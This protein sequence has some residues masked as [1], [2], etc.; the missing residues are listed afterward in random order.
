M[1]TAL[2]DFYIY[3]INNLSKYNI[4]INFKNINEVVLQMQ[5]C[6]NG[7]DESVL[8]DYYS[9]KF[10]K[11]FAGEIIIDGGID[12]T[13]NTHFL[14]HSL[15][16]P[17]I[18]RSFS[19]FDKM[20]KLE[21]QFLVRFLEMLLIGYYVC[22]TN[23]FVSKNK[24]KISYVSILYFYMC[25]RFGLLRSDTAV[26][27]FLLMNCSKKMGLTFNLQL[28][29]FLSS[30]MKKPKWS[31]FLSPTSFSF[32]ELTKLSVHKRLFLIMQKKTLNPSYAVGVIFYDFLVFFGTLI[33]VFPGILEYVEFKT[34]CSPDQ[35]T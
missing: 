15:S 5:S 33:D 26:S 10:P 12:S 3:L 8:M 25:K 14:I 21:A 28:F 1:K 35:V 30:Q 20:S 22:Y 32:F 11:Y 6:S 18:S 34:A 2:K 23:E 7:F 24:L 16:N 17:I 31:W 27:L 29:Y 9:K 13:I 4:S 19:V